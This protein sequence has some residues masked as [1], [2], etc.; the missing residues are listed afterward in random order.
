MAAERCAGCG[1]L[2][3]Q[4]YASRQVAR[5][6]DQRGVLCGSCADALARA[7]LRRGVDLVRAWRYWEG[8]FCS[9]IAS[10]THGAGV[11]K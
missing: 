4:G 10:P 5:T 8:G 2:C 3:G 6:P 11:K 1:V 7:V 9:A